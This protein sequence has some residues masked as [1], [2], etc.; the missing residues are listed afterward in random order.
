MLK[1]TFRARAGA[2]AAGLLAIPVV[3]AAQSAGR[4]AAQTEAVQIQQVRVVIGHGNVAEARRLAAAIPG[5]AGRNLASA[6]ADIFEGKDE[7]ARV[8]LEP[9]ARVNR[10]GDAAVELGLIELRHGQRD[11]AWQRLNPIAA[12][13]TFSGPDDYFRLARAA[14][15]IREFL[16]ANDAYQQIASVPRADIQRRVTNH[17]ATSPVTP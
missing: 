5:A 6:L 8:K 14:R 2:I 1:S 4:G 17:R 16:L 3:L 15:G 9:L 13:R 11:E 7:E 12:V 10:A